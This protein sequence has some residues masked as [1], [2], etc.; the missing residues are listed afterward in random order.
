MVYK[1]VMKPVYLVLG[2]FCSGMLKSSLKKVGF[3]K[4]HILLGGRTRTG[5]Q[6]LSSLVSTWH[7]LCSAQH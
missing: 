4:A 6:V 3:V 1:C 5:A 2:S 7:S